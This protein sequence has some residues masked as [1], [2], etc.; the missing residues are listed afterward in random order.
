MIHWGYKLFAVLWQLIPCN[1]TVTANPMCL[2][3]SNTPW[4]FVLWHLILCLFTACCSN[5]IS[6]LWQ[7][8]LNLFRG[9]CLTYVFCFVIGYEFVS[10]F[11]T[12]RI[13]MSVVTA[14]VT[15][16]CYS[17]PLTVFQWRQ[18]TPCVSTLTAVLMRLCYCSSFSASI[19]W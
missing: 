18:L 10:V 14:H 19:L 5:F 13:C 11:A 9:C 15:Y 16:L 17:S 1:N 7:L 8:I 12:H 2:F 4:M 3:C 6:V